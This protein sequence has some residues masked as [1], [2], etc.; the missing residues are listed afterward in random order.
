MAHFLTDDKRLS[1]LEELTEESMTGVEIARYMVGILN[2]ALV[3][4]VLNSLEY[5]GLIDFEWE[6]GRRRFS[7]NDKGRKFLEKGGSE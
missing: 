1:I 6:L 3:T 7:L 2:Y 4:L 5:E